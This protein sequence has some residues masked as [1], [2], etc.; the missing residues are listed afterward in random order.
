MTGPVLDCRSSLRLAS[1]PS[2]AQIAASATKPTTKKTM[3]QPD[4]PS[5]QPRSSA[6]PATFTATRATT[7][8]SATCARARTELPS[9]LP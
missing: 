8:Y 2:T 6:S 4:A 3:N 7:A 9:T 1:E 5:S